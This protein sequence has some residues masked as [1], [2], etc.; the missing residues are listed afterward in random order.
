MKA[1]LS[2]VALL[3]PLEIQYLISELV[4]D[5]LRAILYNFKKLLTNVGYFLLFS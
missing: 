2:R 3:Y 1:T 5:P 4:F